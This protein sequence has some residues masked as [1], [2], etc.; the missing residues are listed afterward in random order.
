MPNPI[1]GYNGSVKIATVAVTWVGT[2]TF[3][4]TRNTEKIGPHIGDANLYPVGTSVEAKFTIKGTIPSGGDPAQNSM[5]AAV[6]DG[7]TPAVDMYAFNGRR[8][9]FATPTYTTLKIEQAANGSHT[10]EAA[11]EGTATI[12]SG[13]SS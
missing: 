9:Q 1:N 7:T 10:F 5:F 11:G 6:L 13:P 3:E 8:I 12:A 4:A 2:W